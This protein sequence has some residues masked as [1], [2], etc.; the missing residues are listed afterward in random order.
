M[1]TIT[2]KSGE[3]WDMV[4]LRAYGDEHFMNVLMEANIQHRNTVIF[5]HGVTLEVPEIDK[6]STAYEVNLP[7]WKRT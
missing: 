3:T 5:R 1:A 7:P 6:N 2:T 4:S